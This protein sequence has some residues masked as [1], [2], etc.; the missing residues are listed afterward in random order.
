[1]DITFELMKRGD[2]REAS[3]LAARAFEDYRY[4]T[5]FFPGPGES[6][7]MLKAVLYRIGL[8]NFGRS[9]FLI[10]RVDEKI[11]T[12]VMLNAPDYKEPSLMQYLLHGWLM[13]YR[14]V[15]FRRLND[16]LAMAEAAEKP[17]HDY[18]K[19]GKDVW[20]LSSITVEPSLQGTGIGSKSLDYMED[21]ILQHGGREVVLLTNSEENMS[22]YKKHGYEVFHECEITYQGK[23]V[24]SWSM[25]KTLTPSLRQEPSRLKQS[26]TATSAIDPTFLPS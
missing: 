6:L 14:D 21:Y 12:L 25:K 11:V 4:V 26:P 13:V 18:Q 16:Y 23:T 9:H 24:G 10:A 7:K 19:V 1:M 17:C 8:T 22:W 15:N 3:E 2:I 20:Y 5:N